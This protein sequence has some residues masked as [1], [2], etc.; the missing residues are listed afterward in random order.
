MIGSFKRGGKLI[1]TL[2]SGTGYL[3]MLSGRRNNVDVDYWTPDNPDGKY[4]LPGGITSGD[5]PKYAN[6][7]G[8]F[9]A[10]YLKIRTMTLGYNFAASSWLENAGVRELREDAAV[11]DRFD[12]HSP[13]NNETGLEPGA[14]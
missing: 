3:N 1:S 6:T 12:L 13:V 10:S 11:Q 4:P 5:N 7:L 8:H 2:H 14:N 9:D